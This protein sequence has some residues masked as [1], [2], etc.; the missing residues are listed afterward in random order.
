MILVSKRALIQAT[1]I[2]L[3]VAVAV[4]GAGSMILYWHQTY[5]EHLVRVLRIFAGSIILD[6]GIFERYHPRAR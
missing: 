5:L 4:D 2:V 6:I 3:G 1:L